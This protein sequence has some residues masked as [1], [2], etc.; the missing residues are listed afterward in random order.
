MLGTG[1][2]GISKAALPVWICFAGMGAWAALLAASSS[3]LGL[4]LWCYVGPFFPPHAP[5]MR[6]SVHACMCPLMLFAPKHTV[7]MVALWRSCASRPPCISSAQREWAPLNV[8]VSPH[9]AFM[10][11]ICYHTRRL[12]SHAGC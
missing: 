1:F 7:A 4:W 10:I 9:D 5:R 2:M 12:L 6:L 11:C 8:D 3:A